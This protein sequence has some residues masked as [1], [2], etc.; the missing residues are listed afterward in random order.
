[1]HQKDTNPV[2]LED[3]EPQTRLGA[4]VEG[5]KPADVTQECPHRSPGLPILLPVMGV[6]SS[7]GSGWWRGGEGE[8]VKGHYRPVNSETT[9]QQCA[10][11]L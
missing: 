5:V 2:S 8:G 3:H 4:P 7:P 1:M 6:D 11:P 10:L 9:T